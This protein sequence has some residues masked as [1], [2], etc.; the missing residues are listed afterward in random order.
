MKTGTGGGF[1]YLTEVTS[2]RMVGQEQPMSCAAA[3]IRQ[4][5]K[6]ILGKDIGEEAARALAKTVGGT[7]VHNIAPAL[8]RV[9]P[10]KTIMEGSIDVIRGAEIEAVEFAM[11]RAR[12][13]WITQMRNPLTNNPVHTVIVH[14]IVEGIVHLRDPWNPVQGYRCQDAG[15]GTPQCIL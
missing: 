15:P 8:R 11:D 12:G 13:P 2:A 9:L 7:F 5:V 10:G 4:M 3:C 1:K 14:E 6:D